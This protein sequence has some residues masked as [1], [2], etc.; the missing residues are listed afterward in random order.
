MS[1][2]API[3]TTAIRGLFHMRSASE[4]RRHYKALVDAVLDAQYA[5]RAEDSPKTTKRPKRKNVKSYGEKMY[6]M[7]SECDRLW[8]EKGFFFARW[9]DDGTAFIFEENEGFK[10]MLKHF[11]ICESNDIRAAVRNMNAYGFKIE[12]SEGRD[13]QVTRIASHPLFTK[14]NT[15]A[16][17]EIKRKKKN[18]A[19]A[20]TGSVVMNNNTDQTGTLSA[21]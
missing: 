7:I 5:A 12:Q 13:E 3:T 21:E 17:G 20:A 18:G 2:P 4:R 19:A 15:E 16:L 11:D 8:R 1:E 6:L 14:D 10:G 9:N